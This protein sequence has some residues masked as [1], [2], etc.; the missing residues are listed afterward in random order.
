MAVSLAY[1]D[2]LTEKY[3]KYIADLSSLPAQDMTWTGEW[4]SCRFAQRYATACGI[5]Q[6]GEIV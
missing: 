6:G 5:A 2:R 4:S 3:M 1:A